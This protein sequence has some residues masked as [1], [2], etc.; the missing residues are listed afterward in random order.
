MYV[1]IQD[2]DSQQLWAGKTWD[3]AHPTWRQF[4]C[5]QPC[6]CVFEPRGQLQLMSWHADFFH[7]EVFLDDRNRSPAAGDEKGN[8]P[9]LRW[10]GKCHAFWLLETVNL[11]KHCVKPAS[12]QANRQSTTA[13][14]KLIPWAVGQP[15]ALS[16]SNTYGSNLFQN[17]VQ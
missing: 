3:C 6:H 10:G 2:L 16:I 14:S 1:S 4:V 8:T 7:D 15:H 17:R 13:E 12:Q 11:G 5:R 9:L